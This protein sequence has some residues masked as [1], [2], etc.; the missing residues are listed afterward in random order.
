M[1]KYDQNI[2]ELLSAYLDG[3]LSPEESRSIESKI[4]SSPE[5]LKKLEDLRKTKEI[6]SNYFERLPESPFFE[7]RLFAELKSQKPWYKGVLKWSPAVGLGITTVFLMVV[8]K[9]NPQMIDNLIE[10]QSSNIAGFYKENL[11]PLLFAADLNNEDIFNFAMYK[12][13]PLNKE[14]NQMLH[15][16]YDTTGREF[17]EIKDTDINV[18]NNNYEKFV[19]ALDLDDSQKLQIDSIINQYAAE[20]ENQ[21]LVNVNNTVA[22]NSNLWNYQRAIQ[23]D[24]L[25]FAEKSNELQFRKLI[26]ETRS[27]SK[28][29]NLIKAVNDLRKIKNKNYIML[30]PDSVFAENIEF[31]P[32][33]REH[34]FD[35]H[36]KEITDANEMLQKINISVRYDSSWMSRGDQNEWKHKFDIFIDSN[37]CR[38]NM[39]KFDIPVIQVPDFKDLFSS[40]DSIAENFKYYSKYIPK[41]RYFDNKI[42]FEFDADS[43]KS[44]EFN[45]YNYDMDSLMRSRF[46]EMDSI[47]K[48]N[49]N[50]FF[51][52]SDSM[53]TRAFPKFDSYFKYYHGPEDIQI[54]MGELE[55]ELEEFKKEM[56]EWKF[57]DKD[58]SSSRKQ[59]NS[60]KQ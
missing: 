23:A 26:P 36:K 3:E 18:G 33:I 35:I 14:N 58:R 57:K 46:D 9:F 38:I 44:Y 8:L 52:L 2:E 45:I 10:Q 41:V 7:T 56:K 49:F 21:I 28:D 59:E 13:L 51:E 48:F 27:F 47:Q 42:K 6:V 30:T 24:L 25:A 43:V 5:L 40:Y 50:N 22:I 16:G 29:P 4:N 20:L 53:L 17:F 15:L 31:E 11:Q 19:I 32:A 37:S 54:Q 39:T 34:K 55:K 1:K 60:K 12:Q